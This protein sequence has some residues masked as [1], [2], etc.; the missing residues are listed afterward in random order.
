MSKRYTVAD[1]VRFVI[2]RA[3]LNGI[4]AIAPIFAIGWVHRL[5][6]GQ[7]KDAT[8]KQV[9]AAFNYLGRTGFIRKTRTGERAFLD[10]WEITPNAR[11]EPTEPLAAKVGSTDGLCHTVEE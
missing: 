8:L 4:D 11:S 10:L 1:G 3:K 6:D 9:C 2:E 5:R 7:L